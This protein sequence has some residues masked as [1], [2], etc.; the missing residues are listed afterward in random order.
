MDWARRTFLR[1]GAALIGAR[2]SSQT[3]LAPGCKI[4][5]PHQARTVEAITGQIIPKDDTP[6]AIEAGVLYYIDTGLAGDLRRHRSKYVEG[7]RL[8]DQISRKK[9][10]KDF[11]ELGPE[12]QIGIL[13]TLEASS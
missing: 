6:G 12:Q 13:Q 4:F 2:G 10:G 11:I 7:L 1:M 5:S 9:H 8:L 3:V